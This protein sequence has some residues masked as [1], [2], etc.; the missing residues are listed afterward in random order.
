MLEQ[1]T[2]K[3]KRLLPRLSEIVGASNV[4]AEPDELVVYECDGYTLQKAMPD[5]V[6]LPGTTEEVSR[7]VKLLAAEDV[8]FV[9]RG[10]GTSLSGGTLSRGGVT[11]ALTRMNRIL[12]IDWANRRA[13]V[14]PGVVNLHISNAVVAQK[15]HYAPDPSSQPA[16]TIGGNINTNSGGPHTLKYGVTTNH[17]LAVEMVLSDGEIVTLGGPTDDFIGYDLRGLAIGSEGTFGTVTKAIVRLTPSPEA[18]K[19]FLAV[20]ETVDDASATVSAIIRA[21]IVP[22]ALEMMDKLIV[23]AVEA[24]YK[25]GFPTDAG[26]VLII[27]LD[28]LAVGLDSQGKRIETI[29]RQNKARDVR[30]AKDEAERQALWKCRK[31]AFG[32]IGRLSPNYCTQDGVIPRSKLPEMMRF[33]EGVSKKYGVRIANVF[34]AGD[35]NLHP[36]LLYDERDEAQVKNVFAA[37]HEILAKCVELGGSITGEHGIGAEKNEEF[38]LM[39]TADDMDTMLRL[40]RVF[41]PD[42]LCNPNK[43]FPSSSHCVETGFRPRKQAAA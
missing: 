12:E 35:G 16:C 41:N 10:A 22:A 43:I 32:A 11:I 19:T 2:T 14:E 9:P 3:V 7:V 17:V 13:L 18:K 39:F 36:L 5:V 42:N 26:A 6:V 40:R 27:E 8:P 37:S 24:A 23:G 15:L 34:H 33:L 25:F 20:F 30:V 21:G 4:I 29:C 1:T 31:R 38:K 28:G